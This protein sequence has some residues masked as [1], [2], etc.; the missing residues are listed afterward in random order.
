MRCIAFFENFF[1]NFFADNLGLKVSLN[2]NVS[3]QS[4]FKLNQKVYENTGKFFNQIQ[5][6]KKKLKPFNK[7]KYS[8]I[9]RM[10]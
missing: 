8:Y 7:T 5:S 2:V 10:Y 9:L 4:K 6:F 1:E 3:S